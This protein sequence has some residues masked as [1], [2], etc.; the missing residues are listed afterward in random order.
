MSEKLWIYDI[1]ELF[2][3]IQL[4]P[5][6]NDSYYQKLNTIVRLT[7]IIA[8]IMACWKPELSVGMLVTVSMATIIADSTAKKI[9][10]D[11]EPFEPPTLS[12]SGEGNRLYHT[13]PRTGS[14]ENACAFRGDAQ[15][16]DEFAK[17]QL[18]SFL[19]EFNNNPLKYS[20]NNF[21]Q[22][23]RGTEG[24]APSRFVTGGK[25]LDE[26]AAGGCS[27]FCND[28]VP[29]VFDETYKSPNN[30]SGPAN[31]KTGLAPIVAP[32]IYDLDSWKTNGFVVNSHINETRNFDKLNSGYNHGL[33][34]THCTTRR[35]AP[36][37]GTCGA[38]NPKGWYQQWPEDIVGGRKAPT[39]EG[40][41]GKTCLKPV[42]GF[43]QQQIKTSEFQTNPR[44]AAGVPPPKAPSNTTVKREAFD[45]GTAGATTGGGRRF[46]P[47]NSSTQDILLYKFV[48][49]L[50]N[51]GVDLSNRLF[52]RN[53]V[54]QELANFQIPDDQIDKM[55]LFIQTEGPLT[56]AAEGQRS[57]SQQGSN[58]L[59]TQHNNNTTTDKEYFKMPSAVG[60][61][62]SSGPVYLESKRKDMLLT[63]TI[64]P[65]VY[66]KS[67]IGEPI[68]SNIG[69]SY[70]QDWGPVEV[71]EAMGPD[72][73]EVIKFTEH[74]P[75]NVTKVWRESKQNIEQDVSNVYDPRFTGYGTSY[76]G[77]TDSMTGQPKFFY[78]D[79][80]AITK[81]NYISR[82]NLD[83]FP[84]ASTYG[85]YTSGS[86]E[87]NDYKQ[88]ANN[89]FVDSAITFRTEMMERLMR[90]RN[91]ENW[92]RR[93]MPISTMNQVSSM[94]TAI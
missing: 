4:I 15:H 6:E 54:K 69:I 71:E 79:I 19:K 90:K 7:I 73:T 42:H 81:P 10:T 47:Q 75:K 33:L 35:E 21:H 60:C 76:R 22:S 94:P 49:Q 5:K 61:G 58:A 32:P 34:P 37:G 93:L 70:L 88:L 67:H 57:P 41:K 82:H 44:A 91:A 48:R 1:S 56:P 46:A 84:W 16:E 80:D 51:S 23:P 25:N 55:A 85:Q 50:Y 27:R 8:L 20:T 64:V 72:Q 74:D 14:C 13:N 92:Q 89:T 53:M 66:Q 40:V 17:A 24:A 12:S 59:T 62:T 65:G 38:T 43:S 18:S 52:V 9:D 29:L 28:V 78:K 63:N 2:K 86:D 39:A 87:L 45:G 36:G 83:I 30:L 3:S 77:Y 68:Q 26:T 31:P 11:I